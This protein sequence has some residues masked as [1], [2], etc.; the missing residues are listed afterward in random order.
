MSRLYNWLRLFRL[1]PV[2]GRGTEL[3][4]MQLLGVDCCVERVF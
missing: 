1:S 2:F 3:D 4:T